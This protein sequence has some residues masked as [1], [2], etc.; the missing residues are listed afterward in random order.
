MVHVVL[1][2]T[3]WDVFICNNEVVATTTN[4]P[5]ALWAIQQD[6]DAWNKGKLQM[7]A[8]LILDATK[9]IL[10]TLSDKVIKIS[11]TSHTGHPGPLTVHLIKLVSPDYF[12]LEM[13]TM[14]FVRPPCNSVF[15]SHLGCIAKFTNT[16]NVNNRSHILTYVVAT[17][18]LKVLW[19]VNLSLPFYN[20]FVN[21][22]TSSSNLT[23]A[24][25]THPFPLLLC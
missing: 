3:Q 16:P 23:S 5:A 1:S 6:M 15:Q 24:K 7:E 9:D 11:R 12:P 17:S 20:Y 14:A 22:F 8:I 18:S 13:L 4:I 2:H 21:V 10:D 25:L 19:Q